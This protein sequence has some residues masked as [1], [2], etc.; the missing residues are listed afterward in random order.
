MVTAKQT[1]RT[2]LRANRKKGVS[3][4][5]IEKNGYAED[6]VIVKSGINNT[7]ICRFA[8]SKGAWRPKDIEILKLLGLYH[9][10]PLRPK[11]I[12]DMSSI[13]LLYCLN[14]RKPFTPTLTPQA[15]KEFI[16]SCKR[17]KAS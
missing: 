1:A 4:R 9:E 2:L 5:H 10:K 7:T 16:K 15:M 8:K 3:W 13:E 6:D 12:S 14:N 11:T 17:A